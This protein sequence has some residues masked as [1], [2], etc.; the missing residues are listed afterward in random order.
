L[1]ADSK[2]AGD[3]KAGHRYNAACVASLA[4][5]GQVYNLVRV[6]MVEAVRR[7]RTDVARI[8]FIDAQR[9]LTAAKPGEVLKRLIEN[10]DRPG[11]VE[12]R[13]RKRRPKQFPLMNEP[14]AVL[15]NRL[16]QQSAAA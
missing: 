2:A 5:A 9:W 7:Q 3:L 13:V 15:R 4:A 10:P 8:N 11:R 14:R 6:V 12:P 16:F 1:A